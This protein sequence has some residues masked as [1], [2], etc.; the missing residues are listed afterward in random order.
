MRKHYFYGEFM[1]NAMPFNKRTIVIH[2]TGSKSAASTVN[3][4]KDRL[5][6]KGTVGYNE[7]I[8]TNGD[9]YKLA[10][11]GRYFHNTGL[12]DDFDCN[13]FS[14]S[15]TG[16]NAKDILENE[17]MIKS[18]RNRI[19]ELKPYFRDIY[20]H[21]ELNP[22]KEDFPEKEWGALKKKLLD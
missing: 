8:D 21:R 9:I 2:W 19:N 20:C 6:G 13:T 7:I 15:F 14:I 10:P 4:L 11:L 16:N 3:Y 22:N 18:A 12:G 5:N 17:R 1:H